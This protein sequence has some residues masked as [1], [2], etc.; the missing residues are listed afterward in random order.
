MD[1]ARIAR[2]L[3]I[4]QSQYVSLL[5]LFRRQTLN[6]LDAMRDAR[7]RSDLPAVFR[8]AHSIKGASANLDLWA[9]HE[10]AAEICS[11]ANHGS[12]APIDERIR[13]IAVELEAIDRLLD[14]QAGESFDES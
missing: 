6:D 9:I 14:Q 7:I 5:N 1:L 11:D 4:D 13:Q 2:E 3:E 12:A 10:I 8:A